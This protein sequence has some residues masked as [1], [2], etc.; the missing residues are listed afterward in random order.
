MFIKRKKQDP[1][2]IHTLSEDIL[3]GVANR[4]QLEATWSG[5]TLVR[6]DKSLLEQGLALELLESEGYAERVSGGW[7]LTQKGHNRALE[8]LRAHRLV[9]TYLAR[10]EGIAPD[11]L[12][13]VAEKAE[14]EFSAEGINKL[15]D[16]MN[17]PRFDPHGDPIPERAQDL[18]SLE[19]VPLLDTEAGMIGRIAHIEDEPKSEFRKLL[20][21]GLALELPI[22]IVGKKENRIVFELTGE[23]IELSSRLAAHVE[24]IPVDDPN[25]YPEGLNRLSLLNPGETGIVEYLSPA[26]MGPERRRLL[27]FGIVPGSEIQCEFSSP[28]GSPIAYSL[29]GTTIALRQA[30]ARKVFIRRKA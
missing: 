10:K 6:R 29:R 22:K 8:L 24:V 16:S 15:A 28:F 3:K 13:A 14:H 7:H 30:Q 23:S 20:D 2:R 5:D 17:R 27:D 9:E 4:G 11:D 25:W 18:T 12:H 1:E 21:K 26:C 19:Q